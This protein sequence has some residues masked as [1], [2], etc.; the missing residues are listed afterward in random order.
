M[1]ITIQE[2]ISTDAG[3]S[4]TD[5]KHAKKAPLSE[6]NTASSATLQAVELGSSNHERLEST[7]L[8]SEP[9]WRR[10]AHL[11]RIAVPEGEI[12]LLCAQLNSI[13]VFVQQLDEVNVGDVEPTTSVTP[14]KLEMREDKVTDGG[15]AARVLA[16]APETQDGFFLVPKVVE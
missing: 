1:A 3:V 14:M 8:A 13:L 6:A 16:N 5:A 11:A 7:S 12:H 9:M 4:P 10:V 2:R 15:D